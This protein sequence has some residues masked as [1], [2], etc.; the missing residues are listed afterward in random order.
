MEKLEHFNPNMAEKS[1]MK[2]VM[3]FVEEY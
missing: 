2:I 1:Y 3:D